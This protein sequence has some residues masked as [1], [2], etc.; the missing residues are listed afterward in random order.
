MSKKVAV[1]MSGGVDSSVAAAL[2]KQQGYQV[3]GL[4]MHFWADPD[5]ALEKNIE[6][7]CCSLEAREAARKVAQHLDIPLYTVNFNKQFKKYVVDE[8][9]KQY[10]L[11]I[12]PN[13]CI[14]CNKFIKFDALLKKT[15][16][17]KADYLATGHYIRIKKTAGPRTRSSKQRGR[18][19]TGAR[20]CS[21]SLYKAKDKTKDQSYFL[22]NLKAPQLNKLLFPVGSFQKTEIKKLAK[23]FKLPLPEKKES[24]DVCFA[25]KKYYYEFLKKYLKNKIKPG[26]IVNLD[27]QKKIGKHKGLPLYTL[28]QRAPVGGPGPYF[29]VETDYKKNILF[30]TRQEKELFT[31]EFK[32]KNTNWINGQEPK[33]PLKCKVQIRYHHPDAECIIEKNKVVKSSLF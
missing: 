5:F 32:I 9:V 17:L 23:K 21:Y 18:I 3:F 1:A 16:S 12:T 28:G 7:R 10:Q 27:D 26:D 13:P 4:F 33:F 30:V 19:T 24:Q 8:F 29:V 22:Y 31:D 11:G 15:N 6:N 25:P 14:F 2:L 20:S